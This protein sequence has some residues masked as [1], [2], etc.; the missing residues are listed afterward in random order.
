[1]AHSIRK[2]KPELMKVV[3]NLVL[4]RTYIPLFDIEGRRYSNSDSE[5]LIFILLIVNV[6]FIQ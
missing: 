4:L 3:A 6:L 5:N 1:M 2:D